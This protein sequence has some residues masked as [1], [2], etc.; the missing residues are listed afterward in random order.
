MTYV[1]YLQCMRTGKCSFLLHVREYY[2]EHN[3]LYSKEELENYAARLLQ[4]ALKS[5]EEKPHID[6]I[7]KVE[8]VLNKVKPI[9][10]H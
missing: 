3:I 1:E 9:E 2:E 7:G 10:N 6:Y 4:F 8:R 5:L